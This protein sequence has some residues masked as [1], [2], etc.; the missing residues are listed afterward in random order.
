MNIFDKEKKALSGDDITRI[1]NGKTNIIK[2]SDLAN[3]TDINEVL[4]GFRSC[5]ILILTKEDF[6]HWVCITTRGNILEFF[7]S[8]GYF[9]DDPI[10]FNKNSYYFRK[11]NNQDY[12][13]LS[14]LLYNSD[15][16]IT[17]NELPFQSSKNYIATCGRH[18]ACRILNKNITLYKYYNKLKRIN[19]DLDIAVVILTKEI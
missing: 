16:N 7:D 19:K 13:H 4:F 6:G 3:I 5:V 2:Y 8:Y 9:I 18:V 12:P 14:C 15:Y 17:Y 11:K 10:Y 1:V